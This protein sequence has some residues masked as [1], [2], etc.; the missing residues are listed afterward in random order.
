MREQ[1]AKY[2]FIFFDE[3]I[4]VSISGQTWIEY[5]TEGR[6]QLQKVCYHF[7][8]HWQ[9]FGD[10][11]FAQHENFYIQHEVV[12]RQV[13]QTSHFT[14]REGELKRKYLRLNVRNSIKH[15]AIRDIRVIRRLKSFEVVSIT[16][17]DGEEM[18]LGADQYAGILAR[19]SDFFA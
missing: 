17:K 12:A 2:H 5:T 4:I 11:K 15:I 1:Q 16:L 13:K 9:E 3:S 7:G 19:M 10:M 6:Y 8:E 14:F 18:L